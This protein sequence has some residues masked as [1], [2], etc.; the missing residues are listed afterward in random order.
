MRSLRGEALTT[1][2]ANAQQAADQYMTVQQLAQRLRV[3]PDYLYSDVLGQPDGIPGIRL[4]K[5]RRP[6]WRIHPSD[7]AQWEERQRRSY[8]SAPPLTARAKKVRSVPRQVA[9]KAS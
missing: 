2:S 9:S 4:G 5:G 1:T 7:V 3:T 6:R 8:D